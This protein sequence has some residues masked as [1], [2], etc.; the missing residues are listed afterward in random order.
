MSAAYPY[1]ERDVLLRLSE[2]DKHAFTVLFNHYKDKIYTLAF[3]ITGCDFLAEETV[4]DIFTKVWINR[5]ELPSVTHFNAWFN[6][7]ARNH[8]FSLMRNQAAREKREAIFASQQR[9]EIG[10]TDQR[11]VLKQTEDALSKALQTLTPRQNRIYHLIREQGMK[12][13]EVA[14]QLNISRETVKTHLSKAVKH[15]RTYFLAHKD[16]IIFWIVFLTIQK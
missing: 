5:Q 13:E 7:V 10:D 11:I 8:L 14:T 15:L 9:F 16:G 4:Q 2:G 6:T 12:N 1:D 3:K